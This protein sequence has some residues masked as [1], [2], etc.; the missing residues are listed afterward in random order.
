[1]LKSIAI[2]IYNRYFL[3]LSL[4][5]I[6]YLLCPSIAVF[7]YIIFP[8]VCYLLYSYYGRCVKYNIFDLLI[9]IMLCWMVITWTCNF[10]ANQLMLIAR[11][12]CSQIAFMMFYFIGRNLH[13]NKLYFFFEKS[14]LP[15]A[16][17]CVVGIYWFLRPPQW[18]ISQLLLDNSENINQYNYMEFF[19]LKSIFPSPYHIA[20]M[21]SFCCI[22]LLFK[23]Y[24]EK[25]IKKLYLF[26]LAIYP[27]TMLYAM[28]RAPILLFLFSFFIAVC[29]YIM[30]HKRGSILTYSICIV[31][32][33]ILIFILLVS[34]VDVTYVEYLISKFNSVTENSDALVD[35]RI[36]IGFTYDLIGDGA[37]RHAIYADK[38]N[39]LTSI[40][41][42]EYVK[43]LVEQ[44]YV[45]LFL[46]GGLLVLSLAKCIKYFKYLPFELCIIVFFLITMIGANPLS[47]A[48]KHCF[49]IWLIIG[50]V[51]SFK[52]NRIYPMN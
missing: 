23:I 5:A 7:E 52:S 31:F 51:S 45:G 19:R 3:F 28:M 38:Y 4:N 39:P 32:A 33:V 46:L 50:R 21:C 20:Y 8:L 24:K 16:I 2:Y 36:N 9:W 47:T 13:V 10:Y 30:Y 15:L 44:G 22:Y 1:M 12:I 26:Y 27:I 48:D 25:R 11:C 18:Y 6:I 34:F 14:L 43:L 37:G 49:I 41:D 17:C 35:D 29:Y 40:K 42:S